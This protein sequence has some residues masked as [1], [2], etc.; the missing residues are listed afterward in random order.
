MS[1]GE[2]IKKLAQLSQRRWNCELLGIYANRDKRGK[3]NNL[4]VH[5]LWRACDLRFGNLAERNQAC[6]WFTQH[7]DTLKID[8]IVD[9][10]FTDKDKLGRQAYGRTWRCDKPKWQHAKKGDLVGGGS[11][12]ACFLHIEVGSGYITTEDGRVFEA[13][14]RSLPKP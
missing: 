11:P 6:D 7:A 14:W 9:Y 1:N 13:A 3:P 5:A 8:L 10:A 12:W 2:G 4:S